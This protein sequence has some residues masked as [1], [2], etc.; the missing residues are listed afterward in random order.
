MGG[1]DSNDAPA[2]IR[3]ARL[4]ARSAG[5]SGRV[6]DWLVVASEECR[7]GRKGKAETGRVPSE[8]AHVSSGPRIY[9][10]RSVAGSGPGPTRLPG[11]FRLDLLVYLLRLA[12]KHVDRTAV[13]MME[14]AA[15]ATGPA[16]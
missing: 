16:D 4:P 11:R 3:C 6:D 13:Q 9:A 8:L 10:H 14:E 1:R 2:L 12:G 5:A 15:W 7:G